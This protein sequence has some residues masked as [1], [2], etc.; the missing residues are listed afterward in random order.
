MQTDLQPPSFVR[1]A[2][3]GCRRGGTAEVPAGWKG[4]TLCSGSLP[5]AGA[6]CLT[7]WP[8]VCTH[9]LASLRTPGHVAAGEKAGVGGLQLFSCIFLVDHQPIWKESTPVFTARSH[10]Q[11]FKCIPFRPL[12]GSSDPSLPCLQSFSFLGEYLGRGGMTALLMSDPS[13]T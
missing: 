1:V 6:Q 2:T 13:S 8:R 12:A 7:G 11:K 3:G 4:T 9:S 5:F 10:A